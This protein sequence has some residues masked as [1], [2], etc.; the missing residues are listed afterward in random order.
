MKYIT[1]LFLLATLATIAAD[2]RPN[3][4]FFLVD[5]LG[6]KDLSCQGS[7]YYQT[8]NID[9]LSRQ[10]V[11]FTEAYATCTVCSPTRSSCLT[12]KYPARTQI[13]Q[14]LPAGRW[15]PE[16]NK[17]REGRFLRSLPLEEFTLAETFREAGY[18]TCFIGKWHLGGAP[19]SL[20]EHHGFD[21][22]I[23]GNDHGAPGSYFYPFKGTW[24]LPTTPH[25]VHKQA[26][27]GGKKGDYLT[28]VLTDEATQFIDGNSTKPFLL[29]FS[30]YN[31]HTPIQ[32]KKDKVEKYKTR[33]PDGKQ[34]NPAYAAMIESVDDSVGRVM[35]SLKKHGVDGN[36]IIVFASDNGGFAGATSNHPLRANKGSYYEGGIR[37]PMIIS[38]PTMKQAGKTCAVPTNSNDFY[39]T[40]LQAAGLPLMPHQHQ[41]G[42]SLLP[43][44]N[45]PD[46][47]SPDRSLYWHYPHYNQHPSAFPCGVVRDG[48][49]KLIEKYDDGT[50]ELYNLK[51]DLSE[52][53][54]VAK[55]HPDKAKQLLTRL[56]HWRTNVGADLMKPNPYYKAP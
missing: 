8:P 16:K 44:L 5:D 2:K 40:L 13:T 50:L 6:W 54:N 51:D 18:R 25:R 26:Y 32:G 1:A 42:I 36:T 9:R 33:K 35:E 21:I 56:H 39:P 10:G 29:Y 55:Q 52:T 41:D 23:G 31:V 37:T 46:T 12:G 22:N 30:Y 24:Q 43:W 27:D 15:N 45:K 49:W 17:H 3:I 28:D 19:F 47:P 7:T 11:R 14:W 38:L 34:N 20:P 53:T 48:D 4:V